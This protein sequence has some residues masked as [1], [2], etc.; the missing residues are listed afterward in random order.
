MKERTH[1]RSLSQQFLKG[2]YDT[3]QEHRILKREV[4]DPVNRNLL[5]EVEF[6][7]GFATWCFVD[8]VGGAISTEM[9]KL[10]PMEVGRT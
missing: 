9:H 6:W 5:E 4:I 7:D 3:V 2:I 1:P 10:H 8:W